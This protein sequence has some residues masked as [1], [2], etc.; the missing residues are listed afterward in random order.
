MRKRLERSITPPEAY[1]D[2]NIQNPIDG[3]KGD[4]ELTN[5]EAPGSQMMVV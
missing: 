5:A 1:C 3:E 2:V 4:G